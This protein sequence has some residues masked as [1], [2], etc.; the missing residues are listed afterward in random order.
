M[1]KKESRTFYMSVEGINC[2]TLYFMHLAKLINESGSNRYNLK[3]NPKVASPIGNPS[4]ASGNL[5][6]QVWISRS[7]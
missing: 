1:I 6:D 7:R 2:E 4:A 5:R 3:V